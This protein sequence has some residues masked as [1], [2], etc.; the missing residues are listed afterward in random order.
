MFFFIIQEKLQYHKEFFNHH[1]IPLL[2]LGWLLLTKQEKKS[3]GK[4]VEQMEP[5][6]TAGGIVK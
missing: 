5:T 4:E 6:R 1:E 3:A 2:P